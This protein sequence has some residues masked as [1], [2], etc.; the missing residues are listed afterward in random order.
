MGAKA[1]ALISRATIRRTRLRARITCA[2]SPKSEFWNVM[3]PGRRRKI[4][5]RILEF[6]RAHG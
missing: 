3:P 2:T 6:C 5:D 4:C 1:P